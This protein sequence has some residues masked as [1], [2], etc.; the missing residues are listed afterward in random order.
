M[1]P[2]FLLDVANAR[3]SLTSVW[4]GETLQTVKYTIDLNIFVNLNPSYLNYS[5]K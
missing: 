3:E 4:A 2:D 5:L 1:G